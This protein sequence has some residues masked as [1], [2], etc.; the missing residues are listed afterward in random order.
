MSAPLRFISGE[1]PEPL[2]DAYS[3]AVTHAARTVSPSVVAIEARSGRRGGNGS[4]FVFTPD[5]FILTNSH[6]VHG[7]DRIEVSLLDG[8]TTAAQLVGEDEHSDLAVLRINADDLIAARLGD[9]SK[10]QPGQ[11]VVAV[12]NPYGLQYTVTAGVVSALGR[13]M[14]AQSGRL[15]DNIVQTDAALNPGNSGGPLVTADGAVVGVNTA[16]FPGQGICFAIASNTAQFIGA[17]LLRE[18]R[19]KRGYLGVAGQDIDLPRPLIRAHALPDSRAVLIVSVEPGSPAE[20]AGL[21]EGDVLLAFED[22]RVRSIDDLH[23]R[24]TMLDLR[25]SYRLTILRKGERL[26]PLVLPIEAA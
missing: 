15:I 7:A 9:S 25:R 4:G 2:L 18:G 5:G 8:R 24:L 11:L 3:Q 6:V 10:L 26:Q 16:V 22:E 14:R 20:T 17:T 13:S 12:G 19:V 1:V 23:R 21:R